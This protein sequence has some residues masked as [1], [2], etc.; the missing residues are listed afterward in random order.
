M[1]YQGRVTD[2]KDDRGFGFITPNGG[3]PRVFVHIS[4]FGQGQ[5]RP[6]ENDLVTYELAHD[7]KKRDRAENVLFASARRTHV[8]SDRPRYL[9]SILSVIVV[10]GLGVYGW[11]YYKSRITRAQ[12]GVPAESSM[13][14]G[15]TE[16]FRCEGKR[17]CSEMTSC[18]EATFYL[19]NCPGVQI[20]G[21]RD[22]IP[23]ES[24]WCGR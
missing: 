6:S 14:V 3:G 12:P 10:A 4:A 8:R 23:C 7:E 15:T 17:Y 13:Q 24:Q 19:K 16:K 20:D 11:Q 21:D 9:S 18:Q 22:G 2:W 5:R 1:R